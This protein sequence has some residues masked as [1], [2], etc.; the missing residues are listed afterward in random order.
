MFRAEALR[1]G[2]NVVKRH[3]LLQRLV[4]GGAYHASVCERIREWHAQLKYVRTS[5]D[6]LICRAFARFEGRVAYC[7]IGDECAAPLALCLRK[8][9]CYSAAH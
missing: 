1:Q 6:Y 3:A 5:R 2:D 8:R 4:C 9:L 7:Q